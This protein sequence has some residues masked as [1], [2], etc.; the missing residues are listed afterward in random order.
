MLLIPLCNSNNFILYLLFYLFFDLLNLFLF[1]SIV[2]S[3]TL[4]L[5]LNHTDIF[6]SP[7]NILQH[8]LLLYGNW[9]LQSL[10]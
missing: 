6:V 2:L 1:K 8:T 10:K 7:V 5:V 4:D 3:V 9:L